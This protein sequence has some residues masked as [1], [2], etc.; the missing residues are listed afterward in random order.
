MMRWEVVTDTGK[1]TE[2]TDTTTPEVVHVNKFDDGTIKSLGESIAKAHKN[3]QKYLP[4]FIETWGGSAYH[5]LG[6]ISLIENSPVEIHTIVC[7]RAMS[8]GAILFCFGKK[9]FLADGGYLMF[10]DMSAMEWGKTDTIIAST[11]QLEKLRDEMYK[12]TAKAVGKPSNYF[13]K[14]MKDKQNNDWF[15]D[16]KEAKKEKIA[17]NVGIPTYRVKT[18]TE[19][20]YE[21]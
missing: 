16:A 17:T 3:K 12:R 20:T 10:H 1:A 19:Y 8:A 13:L 7:G 2:S 15:L 18:V 5:L 6:L 4:V 11:K 14:K 21:V 9:R